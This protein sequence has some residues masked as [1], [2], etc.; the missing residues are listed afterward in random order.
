MFWK[1]SQFSHEN[2]CEGVSFIKVEYQQPDYKRD[3][4]TDIFLR[5]LRN[6]Q[7]HLYSKASV[8]DCFRF[9]KSSISFFF[10]V[11]QNFI[12][13]KINR[14]QIRYFCK[15]NSLI[16]SNAAISKVKKRFFN[17]SINILIKFLLKLWAVLKFFFTPGKPGCYDIAQKS[18]S[19][20]RKFRLVQ[21]HLKS[22][23]AP[24]WL[25]YGM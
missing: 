24:K 9:S 8:N 14:L 12:R 4:N 20:E 2:T 25:T 10:F 18:S 11:W 21:S 17:I 19:I 5:N 3:S 6:F 22:M 1:T 7:E 13:F 16:W 23:M 15:C